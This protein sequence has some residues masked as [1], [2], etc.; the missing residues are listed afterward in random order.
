MNHL[1]KFKT[2]ESQLSLKSGPIEELYSRI[3]LYKV[4]DRIWAV[5]I[6]HNYL[7]S[8]VFLRCQEYYESTSPYFKNNRFTWKDYMNWYQSEQGPR[9][10][11]DVFTYAN[12]W[13]GFNL[14]SEV[15]EDCL[16]EI[17]D[18][19]H[20]DDIMISIVNT[21]KSNESGNFYLLG[22]SEIDNVDNHLLD[23]ELA[24]GMWYTDSSYKSEMNKLLSEMDKKSVE[25]IKKLIAEIGYAESVISDEAQAYL[26]T[27]IYDEW[28]VDDIPNWTDKFKEVFDKYKSKHLLSEPKKYE[29]NYSDKSLNES[30]DEGNIIEDVALEYFDKYYLTDYNTIKD[31]DF[32]NFW[33]DDAFWGWYN[34]TMKYQKNDKLVIYVK[35]DKVNKD[36]FYQDMENLSKRLESIGYRNMTKKYDTDERSKAVGFSLTLITKSTPLR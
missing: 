23:H 18:P 14:P 8:W 32:G 1:I 33:K 22:I 6:P 10:K 30:I 35:K 28:M 2:F 31:D 5:V 9:G 4:A 25:S 15:I 29:V 20:Y 26:A 36:E 12:D 7:R 17:K 27:G 21:I 11:R 3:S 34:L 24:H 19:N 13:A 16:S